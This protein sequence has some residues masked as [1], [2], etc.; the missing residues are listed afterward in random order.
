MLWG[1]WDATV[2]KCKRNRLTE[3]RVSISSLRDYLPQDLI[4]V[5]Q[6]RHGK[7]EATAVLYLL[8]LVEGTIRESC[9]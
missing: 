5:K 7:S 8:S 1:P 6:R 2:K 9:H 4:P 3:L